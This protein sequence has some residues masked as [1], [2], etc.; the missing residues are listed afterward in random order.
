MAEGRVSGSCLLGPP[1]S[2]LRQ[3]NKSGQ[4]VTRRRQRPEY[5][6]SCD[7]RS[8][9]NL[10]FTVS[11]SPVP[12]PGERARRSA[13]TPLSPPQ[14]QC[15]PP[16]VRRI[17]QPLELVPEDSAGSL[18]PERGFSAV[19][20]HTALL[21]PHVPLPDDWLQPLRTFYFLFLILKVIHLLTKN[22]EKKK[23]RNEILKKAS[24]L[25]LLRNNERRYFGIF[26]AKF[27]FFCDFSVL[28]PI[29]NY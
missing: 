24:P 9:V 29:I 10:S 15:S 7:F 16:A 25:N 22:L 28:P 27:S 18:W 14:A 17:P 3:K 21:W 11:A 23:K 12:Y 20:I 26:P 8:I 5:I 19:S 4:L 6:L 1:A 2:V 13:R